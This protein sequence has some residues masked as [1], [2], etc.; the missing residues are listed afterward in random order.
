MLYDQ[1]AGRVLVVGNRDAGGM[2]YLKR[3]W[4]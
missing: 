1:P 4:L 2:V 3:L